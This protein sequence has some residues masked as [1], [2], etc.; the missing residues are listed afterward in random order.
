M[1][2]SKEI[3]IIYNDVGE[4]PTADNEDT[5]I[6][7][8]E[9]FSA[10]QEI[11]YK[12]V[13]MA[14]KNISDL[15]KLKKTKSFIFNLVEEIDG[16]GKLA[17]LVPKALE[18]LNLQFSGNGSFA[19]EMA[20]DK[21][22]CKQLLLDNKISTGNYVSLDN[23][24]LFKKGTKYIL[25][26]IHECASIGIS[27]EGIFVAET[28]SDVTK[29]IKDWQK[30]FGFSYFADEFIDGREIS[31][32]MLN[33][34]TLPVYE[35]IFANFNDKPKIRTYESKWDKKSEDFDNIDMFV[36]DHDN[37]KE[38]VGKLT[39]IC[40]QCWEV[41]RMSGYSRIDFRVDK[42]GTPYV[43]EINTNP[44][45]TNDDSSFDSACKSAG[46]NCTE[47]VARLI[48]HETKK[49]IGMD[50]QNEKEL[51]FRFKLKKGEE[52]ILC[53]IA[54]GTG[55]FIKE[56]FEIIKYRALENIKQGAEKSGNHFVVAELDGK[57]IGFTCYGPIET[58]KNS[59][60]FFWVI[61]A[62]EHK[63]KG[64]GKQLLKITEQKIAEAGGDKVYI[65][66]NGKPK[67]EPTRKFHVS[68]GYKEIGYFPDYY[69][70][71]D[72]KVTY[73]KSVLQKF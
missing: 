5:L 55:F 72:A 12:P 43:M 23:T 13:K 40:K 59:Y 52:K 30:K 19:T 16:S 28:L 32:C 65:E 44:C 46:I 15:S 51:T 64:Y 17:Y 3:I 7:V 2:K 25:K 37:E 73:V 67:F 35:T 34:E 39:K 33:G 57:V 9:T 47:K 36:I 24:K 22:R 61:V 10:L 60:D 45:I 66:T 68:Q 31:V 27:Y 58:T 29:R 41:L 8:N 63:R 49:G 14:I 50:S 18:D 62:K 21:V 42:T 11:G 1:K 54:E 69:D 53:N 48:Y 20:G 6:M 70:D 38:L 26:P 71:G 4:T 56:D